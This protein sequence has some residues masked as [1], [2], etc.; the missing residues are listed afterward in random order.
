MTNRLRK[1]IKDASDRG[2]RRAN[3]RWTAD[4][5]RR[6]RL[7]NQEMERRNRF[8]VILRDTGTGEER[9]FHWDS[10]TYANMKYHA[11]MTEW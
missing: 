7:H 2:R 3:A 1:K 6:K 5:E 10:R 11:E 8:V 9:V 4:R